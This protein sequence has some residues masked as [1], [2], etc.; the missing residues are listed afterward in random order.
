MLAWTLDAGD[1]GVLVAATETLDRSNVRNGVVVRGQATADQPPFTSLAIHTDPTSPTRWGGPF[2]RIVSISSSTAI[3]SQ[4][5]A[6]QA[7]RSLLNLR[8]GLQRTLTL[9][10]VPNPALE[11]D[12][13]IDVV[14]A[15][16][17]SETHIVNSLDIGLDVG[18][19]IRVGTAMPYDHTDS[20]VTVLQG[21]DVWR[22]L[23]RAQM[24]AA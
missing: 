5:Q 24:A 15:D 23:D 7:A 22:E 17:R 6:D 18:A 9:V 12:D 20:A 14:F 2:G 1:R 4:A 10:G 11:P 8:L 16:G 19:T 21:E 3:G 13:L